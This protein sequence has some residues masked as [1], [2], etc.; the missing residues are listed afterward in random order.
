M[1]APKKQGNLKL[2]LILGS[3]ALVFF[4]SVFIKR[5]WLG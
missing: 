4:A 2:A 3:S 1:A 5:G